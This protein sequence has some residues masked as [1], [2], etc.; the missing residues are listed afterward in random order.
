MVNVSTKTRGKSGNAVV[1]VAVV[2]MHTGTGHSFH[3]NGVCTFVRMY[4]IYN[5]SLN[6]STIAM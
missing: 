5:L 2:H 4:S 1:L 3:S 6:I